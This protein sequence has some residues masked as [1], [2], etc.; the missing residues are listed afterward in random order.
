MNYKE[1]L[2][3]LNLLKK[4]DVYAFDYIEY[5]HKSFWNK[6]IKETD[7]EDGILKLCDN[8]ENTMFYVHIP[9][10]EQLCMFCI[11]HKQITSDYS[12]AVDY[13]KNSL[14]LE[15]DLMAKI[16][17]KSKN[18][19]LNIKEIYFGGGSPTYLREEEFIQLKNKLKSIIDF[20]NLNQ[21]SF[22]ID[23]RRV[24]EN[25]LL[26]YAD[27]G[28]DKLSFGIQDFDEKVQKNINRVQPVSLME[29]LLTSKVRE[30]FRSIN[31]DL[32]I[33]L[34]GQ[35]KESIST[36]IDS[37]IKLKPDR[38]SLTYLTYKPDFHPYQ[39]H[40][41]MNELLPDFYRRKEIFVEALDKLMSSRYVRTG[42][43]HFALPKD[44]VSKSI[45]NR[46][47]YYNSF[48]A[49]TGECRSIL[50]IGRSSY[51]TFG[52]GLYYQNLYDQ[53][54]Y[55]D[56]LQNGKIPIERG[57]V[58]K[59]DDLIRREIIKDIRTY[60]DL[61]FNKIFEKYQ[62]DHEYFKKEFKL[63]KEFEKDK[64]LTFND[65]H[66]LRLNEKGKHFSNLI[67]SVFDNFIDKPRL[68]SEIRPS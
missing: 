6:E 42:F 29:N 12:K 62:I 57:W 35:T 48:G 11:C 39:R 47:A 7:I 15:I 33:G 65:K 17:N 31:F 37:V 5:P 21:F 49:T 52:D 64:L 63:L 22:E 30:K 18:K 28:V 24:D 14:L 9:F 43:E 38:I 56:K 46:K 32:L 58:M 44:D 10:C 50:A 25:R 40:M 66:L 20:D 26:F 3:D 60:F 36:T 55:Q 27:Q 41:M 53:K 67:G 59:K 45:E 61:D 19:K 8:Q 68:N 23:P 1:I 34:P 13:L 2:S 54:E 4:Y 16:I 51:S